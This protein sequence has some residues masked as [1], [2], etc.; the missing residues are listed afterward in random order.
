MRPGFS[1][2]LHLM[3]LLVSS[4][5]YFRLPDTVFLE[6]PVSMVFSFAKVRLGNLQLADGTEREPSKLNCL[7]LVIFFVVFLQSTFALSGLEK[8]QKFT[9]C[10]NPHEK[11]NFFCI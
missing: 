9:F 1:C 5:S 10:L 11:L 4:L 7:F 8:N 2:S 6:M 3:T